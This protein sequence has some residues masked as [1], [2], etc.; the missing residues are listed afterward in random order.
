MSEH[1]HGVDLSSRGRYEASKRVTWVSV[2]LNLVLTVAQIVIGLIGQSQAL[3]ADGFHTLSD[4]VSDFMVLFAL[5]HG[6]KAADAEH[7]YG[8][9][10]IE[11]AMTLILGGMLVAVG[12]GIAINAGLKLHRGEA[13][14]IPSQITLWVAVVTLVG[15]EWLYRYLMVVAN[16]YDSSMLRANA[17]HSRSDAISSLVVVAGI[18]GALFGFAYLD[19]VAAIIVAIMVAKIGADFAWQS[20]RELIDTGLDPAVIEEMR[21]VINGVAGVKALHLLRTRRTGGK[22]LVD[23]HIIVDDHLSVSEG[24]QISET[25][26]ARLI[27]EV[28]VI[29]DVLVHIDTEE[30]VELPT[31]A[32]LPL[33]DEILSRLKQYF[34]DIPEASA[35]ERTTLHYV[36][37]QLEIELLLPLA[38]APSREAASAL[39][40]RFQ[41]AIQ[42]ATDIR[43]L[44]ILYH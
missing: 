16:R 17:W 3:V 21:K 44:E 13:F 32:G 4:L 11:T 1:P 7:P 35:I 38:I 10:R 37:G 43:R 12:I 33:R 9:A 8:H 40:K 24:H 41:T 36:D 23:V 39:T 28:E 18:G 26:R 30:D 6:R 42:G 2:W 34:R 5:A 25:V 20:L 15:K 22:A 29:S 27:R 19:S 31:C 14:V